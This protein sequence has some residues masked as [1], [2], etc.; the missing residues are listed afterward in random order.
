MERFPGTESCTQGCFDP[1]LGWG[2]VLCRGWRECGGKWSSLL[3]Q[4][5]STYM[6]QSPELSAASDSP[7]Y[8]PL[9]ISMQKKWPRDCTVRLSPKASRGEKMGLKEQRAEVS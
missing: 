7:R 4:I 2:S 1:V 8:N 5:V 6:V 3:G 9:P